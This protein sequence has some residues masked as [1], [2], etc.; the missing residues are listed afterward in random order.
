LFSN[1]VAVGDFNG[2]GNLD[3]VVT[4]Q[5][6]DASHFFFCS[7]DDH[8]S[9]TAR[10]GNGDGTFRG[11]LISNAGNGAAFSVAV[12]DFNHDG[13]PDLGVASL[14]VVDVYGFL[15]GEVHGMIGN[16]TGAFGNSY[17]NGA[18]GP[19]PYSLAIGDFN[20][21]GT[22]IWPSRFIAPT[23]LAARTAS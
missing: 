20:L 4:N 6:E 7:N 22:W 15:F 5:C 11:A 14:C 19:C 13:K 12:G 2:D 21:D 9:V 10:L 17:T 1:S 18:G 8:G 16:G 3:L 23:S